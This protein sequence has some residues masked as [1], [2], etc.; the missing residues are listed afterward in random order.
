MKRTLR[1]VLTA[2]VA[3]VTVSALVPGAASAAEPVLSDAQ[4]AALSRTEQAE[5]LGP[6]RALANAVD[7]V[8]RSELAD[9]YS[10][11]ELRAGAHAV[12]V[13]LTDRKQADRL[14]AAARAVDPGIDTGLVRIKQGK[15][16]RRAL[17]E[18]RDRVVA[19]GGLGGDLL[20]V[21][22]P[23]N[24]GGLHLG[25]RDVERAKQALAANGARA[26]VDRA[27]VDTVLDASAEG[28]DMSRLRDSAPWIAGEALVDGGSN[29]TYDCT[30]GVPTRRKSDNRS[31]L[32]SAEHCFAA[33][34]TIYTGW[35]GGRNY[36]GHVAARSDL[37]D[38]VAIDT[39]STGVTAGREWDG[40]TGNSF[41][42][43][44]TSSAYS[45]AGDYVCQDGFTS[46]VVCNIE[47]TKADTYWVGSNGVLH[48]GVEGIQ[49]YGNTAIQHGDSGGLVF[50][51]T[52]SSRQ[53]RGIN[54]WGGDTVIRWTEVLDI[55]NTWGL[56]LAG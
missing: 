52:G 43:P 23:P 38:A 9:A 21:T 34:A 47:V 49:V 8:G 25:V 26:A 22:V 7:A 13:Y 1:L 45:Y 24:G 30:S 20:S 35:D 12:D 48:R 2:A 40:P 3:L 56:Q 54:S 11:L 16:T 50:A 28:S 44:L 51:I 18:A 27:G 53:A 15:Y 36:I 14:L 37:W 17:Q 19:D 41:T 32:I 29:A 10:G 33:D 6:L 42:L 4:V 46:G 31:F 55:Y 5:L 39:S